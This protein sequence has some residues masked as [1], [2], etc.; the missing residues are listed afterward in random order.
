MLKKQIMLPEIVRTNQVQTS[1]QPLFRYIKAKGDCNRVLTICHSSDQPGTQVEQAEAIDISAKG[2]VL[3][4]ECL[5][6]SN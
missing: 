3:G 2:C 6:C 4:I 5:T 1:I